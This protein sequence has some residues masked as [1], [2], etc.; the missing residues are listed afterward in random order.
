[1]YLHGGPSAQDAQALRGVA[2]PYA[3]KISQ[4]RNK[5]P[6]ESIARPKQLG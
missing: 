5:R 4:M 1:V 6:R 2:R 3:A